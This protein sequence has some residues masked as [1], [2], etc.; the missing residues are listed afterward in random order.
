MQVTFDIEMSGTCNE[1]VRSD[2][3]GYGGCLSLCLDTAGCRGA[4]YRE[5]QEACFLQDCDSR[6]L[7]TNTYFW[8]LNCTSNE[9]KGFVKVFSKMFKRSENF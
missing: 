9:F 1:F 4:T 8:H 2:H 6:T 5:E 7:G 3:P